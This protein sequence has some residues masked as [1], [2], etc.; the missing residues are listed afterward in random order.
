MYIDGSRYL[1]QIGNK[2]VMYLTIEIKRSYKKIN[3][4]IVGGGMN[5]CLL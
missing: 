4:R 5:V 1:Y 3:K 2:F